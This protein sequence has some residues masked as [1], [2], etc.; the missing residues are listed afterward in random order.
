VRS[1]GSQADLINNRQN[2]SS[3]GSQPVRTNWYGRLSADKKEEHLK[4]LRIARQ[5]KKFA[6]LSRNLF[7]ESGHTAHQGKKSITSFLLLLYFKLLFY[8]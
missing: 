6:P 8:L 2:D 5:Q 3:G 4:K 7:E 1:L